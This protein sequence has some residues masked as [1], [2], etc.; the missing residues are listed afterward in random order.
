VAYASRIDDTA[1]WSAQLTLS[2]YRA[3][4][5]TIALESSPFF[6][7]APVPNM[8]KFGPSLL[9]RAQNSEDHGSLFGEAEEGA[10]TYEEFGVSARAFVDSTVSSGGIRIVLHKGMDSLR[11]VR[12]PKKYCF[13]S[14]PKLHNSPMPPLRYAK[15]T[16]LFSQNS[17]IVYRG[18]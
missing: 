6:A 13:S 17:A 14:T 8:A 1:C 11:E 3:F 18:A 16:D 4:A 10:S 12:F 7:A 9:V 2:Q 15:H 5:S